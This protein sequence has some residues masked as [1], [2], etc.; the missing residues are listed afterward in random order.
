MEKVVALPV[1]MSGE[2]MDRLPAAGSVV[3]AAVVVPSIV[4]LP[5]DMPTGAVVLIV[6]EEMTRSPAR[7]VAEE[8]EEPVA[9]KMM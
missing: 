5:P 4:R 3:I 9:E 7:F 8:F 6:S 1:T 2:V